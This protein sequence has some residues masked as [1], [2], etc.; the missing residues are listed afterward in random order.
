MRCAGGE[1]WE[2]TDD[3]N[4]RISYG[5]S[6]NAALNWLTLLFTFRV[7]PLVRG[8]AFPRESGGYLICMGVKRNADFRAVLHHRNYGSIIT[9]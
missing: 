4:N 5:P 3:V 6:R 2:L 8:R 7:S 9:L 1:G